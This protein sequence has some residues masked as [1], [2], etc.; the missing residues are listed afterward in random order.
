M[1]R[2]EKCVKETIDEIRKRILLD[3]GRLD[4]KDLIE[5]YNICDGDSVQ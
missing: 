1:N 5:D 4:Q 3:E 2:Y